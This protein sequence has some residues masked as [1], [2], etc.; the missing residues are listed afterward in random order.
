MCAEILK[1]KFNLHTTTGNFNN[2]LGLPITLLNLRPNHAFSLLEMGTN[3][4]GEIARLCK[5]A[6]PNAGLI[7]N[8]GWGHTEFFGDISGV[9][10]AKSE[11]FAALPENGIAFTNSDDPL[12][13]AMPV[14]CR[15]VTFG[16]ESVGVDFTGKINAYSENGCA[17]LNINSKIEIKL[18]IPGRIAALN[19]L[20]AATVGLYYNVDEKAVVAALENF[21]PVSQRFAQVKIGPYHVINDV[22]NANPSSTIAAIATFQAM[23]TPGRKIF[24][25]GDMLELGAYS[26]QGHANVGQAVAAAGLDRFYGV[27]QMTANATTA[28]FRAGMQAV[29]HFETK[30]D[31]IEALKS[32]LQNDDTLLVK[33]SRGSHME[34]IIEELRS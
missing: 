18:K 30:A 21:Q 26:A 11:L 33:G 7:T 27:G 13:A 5:I 4:F 25:M 6:H 34:E 3:H 2:Q 20:A 22:Y 9:A 16:F 10:R 23:K 28:A 12:I 14:K 8:I 19:A 17:R 32:D 1:T 15:Q 24:V 29:F 31:L